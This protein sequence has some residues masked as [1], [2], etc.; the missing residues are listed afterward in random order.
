ME[1]VGSHFLWSGARIM[2]R[3][4]DFSKKYFLWK[5]VIPQTSTVIHPHKVRQYKR[6]ERGRVNMTK[7]HLI[8]RTLEN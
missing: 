1:D 4:L 2:P 7:R 6:A 3:S 8:D 5:Y